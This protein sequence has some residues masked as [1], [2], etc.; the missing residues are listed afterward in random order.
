MIG[1]AA[2]FTSRNNSVICPLSLMTL[3]DL[4]ITNAQRSRALSLLSVHSYFA[5]A[6][7]KCRSRTKG[8]E[9]RPKPTNNNGLDDI[10]NAYSAFS[11]SILQPEGPLRSGTASLS[12]VDSYSKLDPWVNLNGDRL[13]NSFRNKNARGDEPSIS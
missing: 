12:E 11:N 10:F 3:C 2:C 7:F 13:L 8:P 6:L 1:F 9:A 5:R 4:P